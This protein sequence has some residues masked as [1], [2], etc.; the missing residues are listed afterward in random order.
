MTTLKA[1]KHIGVSIDLPTERVY[2]FVSNPENLPKWASGLGGN[3]ENVNGDWFAEAPIGRI[4]I[5]MAE[6]NPYGVLDHDVVFESGV[7]FY[8]PMRVVR[9]GGGSEVVFTLY[10]QAGMSEEKFAEDI[11]WVERD[12]KTLK[13]LL[14]KW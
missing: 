10:Q 7:T 5:K 1:V 14:E 13:E 12:L 3:I 8:N 11:E 4:Q 9:N 2:E 6:K